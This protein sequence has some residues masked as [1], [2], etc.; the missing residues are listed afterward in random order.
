LI[1]AGDHAGVNGALFLA[2]FTQVFDDRTVCDKLKPIAIIEAPSILGLRPTGVE[3]L[4]DTLVNAGLPERLHAR[5]AG[6]VDALAYSDIRDPKIA[7]LNPE[8]IADYSRRLAERIG[9]VLDRG[10]FALVLGGDCSILLGAMLALNRR[11]RSGLLFLDGHM[12]FYDGKSNINGEAASSDLALVTGRGPAVLTTYDG[13]SPLIRDE[14]VVAFGFR[15]E[16]EAQSYGS[17][18]LAEKIKALSLQA[19]R[20]A[21][22]AGATNE[23]LACASGRGLREFWIHFDADVLDD[24]I[25]PAV[26]YRLPGGLTWAE[27]E[28]VLSAALAHPKAVGMEITI[29]NPK[30]DRDGKILSAFVEMLARAFA[31]G[32]R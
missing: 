3:R 26:D 17:P 2:W 8:G 5:N 28:Y 21:G 14:D 18:P 24:A 32:E 31:A 20:R 25:M 23:A 11:G 9:D 22:I 19:V 16:R 4:S 12:D 29:F 10:E 1:R 15:D 30:F 6:R 27:I 7:F 13:R